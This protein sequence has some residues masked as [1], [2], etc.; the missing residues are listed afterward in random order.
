[1]A[2]QGADARFAAMD[3]DKNGS[4]SRE[5]FFAA[6]PN[7]KEG[8]FAALDTDGDGAI[9]LPEWLVFASGHGKPEEHPTEQH[10]E[11]SQ[12]EAAPA[13]SKAPDLIMPPA[14]Q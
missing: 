8:A 12:T 9:S 10:P 4:V 13:P 6:Q 14:K 11:G 5:E 1:M 2:G 3:T 7:M